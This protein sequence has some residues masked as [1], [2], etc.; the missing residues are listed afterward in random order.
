[1][2]FSSL[3]VV[4]LMEDQ[5]DQTGH[6]STC[7]NDNKGTT[8]TSKCRRLRFMEL[9]QNDVRCSAL[10]RVRQTVIAK[11]PF[12]VKCPYMEMYIYCLGVI[13]SL[14]MSSVASQ[15]SKH[16]HVRGHSFL[17]A[18]IPHPTLSY[19]FKT[20]MFLQEDKETLLR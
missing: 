10:N 4:L 18:T 9:P 3:C 13:M 7:R 20:F 11:I 2:P 19:S 6:P 1:M 5:P 17:S 8:P 14:L 16:N 12:I 15:G